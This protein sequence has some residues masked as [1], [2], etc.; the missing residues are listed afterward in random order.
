M[1]PTLQSVVT[2]DSPRVEDA[3]DAARLALIELAI[4]A[5]V[6]LGGLAAVQVWLAAAHAADLQP[7]D[8]LGE[9]RR[10]A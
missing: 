7:P 6:V 9:R 4:A 8:D 5:L 2:A 3:F 1:L 10:P